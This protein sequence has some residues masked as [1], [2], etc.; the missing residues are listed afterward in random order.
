MV[1]GNLTLAPTVCGKRLMKIINVKLRQL[2]GTMEYP[3]VLW[4][5]RGARPL[6]S[7][8]AFRELSAADT[9]GRQTLAVGDGI[10]GKREAKQAECSGL[11]V[12]CWNTTL[13]IP[14]KV[15]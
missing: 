2:Q 7:Y 11:L 4:E 10:A 15:K 6:D 3:G 14:S 13:A 12:M 5:E 1:S 9:V 8:P